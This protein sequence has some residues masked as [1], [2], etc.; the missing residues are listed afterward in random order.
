MRKKVILLL[1][2][3]SFCVSAQEKMNNYKY[4]IVPDK[5]DFQKSENQYNLNMLLKFKFQ[6]MG[7]ETFLQSDSIPR[8]I[9]VNTCSFLRPIII[10]NST[11]FKT[12]LRVQILNCE[13]EVLFETKEGLSRSKNY[14]TSYNE[15][16]RSALK[17]FGDYHLQFEENEKHDNKSQIKTVVELQA[18]VDALK[19]EKALIISEITNVGVIAPVVLETVKENAEDYLIAKVTIFGYEL[20]NSVSKKVEF[21]LYKTKLK[22]VYFIKN[23]TGVVYKDKDIWVYESLKNKQIVLEY[24]SIKSN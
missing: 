11:M 6:Q 15:A 13:E 22:D 1:I 14:K 3:F 20:I 9:K 24:L 8:E 17:S 7:F 19:K 2:V 21:E 5:F 18:E 16:I 23:Q 12:T 10:S 4:I